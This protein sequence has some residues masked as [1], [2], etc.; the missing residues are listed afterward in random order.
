[1]GNHASH[2]SLCLVGNAPDR[3]LLPSD[4]RYLALGAGSVR[5]VALL[6]AYRELLSRGLR[7]LELLGVSGCSV[8]SILGLALVLGMTQEEMVQIAT[9]PVYQKMSTA[10]KYTFSCERA[11]FIDNKALGEQLEAILHAHGLSSD[12]TFEELKRHRDML[13]SVVAFSLRD[14]KMFSFNYQTTPSDKVVDA[15]LASSAMPTV[16]PPQAINVGGE[17]HCFV[18]G[19]VE[20]ELPLREFPVSSTL[21]L[22]LYDRY[23]NRRVSSM[24][25]SQGLLSDQERDRIVSIDVS[26]VSPVQFTPTPAIIKWLLKQG[27]DAIVQYYAHSHPLSL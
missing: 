20:V 14:K 1:M 18:D 19:A 10:I 2:A 7:P 6:G 16:F 21:G 3:P 4:I 15:I 22:Y 23:R 9:S 13:F 11:S 26:R 5:G 17:R 27:R 24:F 12:V 8:G 25:F